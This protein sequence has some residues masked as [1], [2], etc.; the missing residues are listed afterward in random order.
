[1]LAGYVCRR[2]ARGGAAP[3]RRGLYLLYMATISAMSLAGVCGVVAASTPGVAQSSVYVYSD[4]ELGLEPLPPCEDARSWCVEDSLPRAIRGSPWHTTSLACEQ[5]NTGAQMIQIAVHSVA[6]CFP[7]EQ[8]PPP[9]SKA[10]SGEFECF[11]ASPSR[12]PFSI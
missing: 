4:E 3:A 1:M 11:L 6:F 2:A 9:A 7:G 5:S 12:A 8:K 10:M